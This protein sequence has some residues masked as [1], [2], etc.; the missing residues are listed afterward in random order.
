MVTIEN[1]RL[2]ISDTDLTAF[3]S[4]K[5][6]RKGIRNLELRFDDGEVHLGLDYPLN[7]FGFG[8]ITAR[9]T[10]ALAEFN[11]TTQ[12]VDLCVT[13]FDLREA[14]EAGLLGKVLGH[15]VGMAKRLTG[16]EVVK[17]AL[18][19]L[20]GRVAFLDIDAPG[21]KISVRLKTI[22][23]LV[24]PWVHNLNPDELI[25]SPGKLTLVQ[26]ARRNGQPKPALYED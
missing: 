16:A 24:K 17:W 1:C 2:N 12:I 14:G 8:D 15:A 9:V 3:L 20:R 21:L 18:E 10:V 19:R 22:A 25:L 26:K 13:D 11:A 4:P 7:R 23:A 5:L 6:T